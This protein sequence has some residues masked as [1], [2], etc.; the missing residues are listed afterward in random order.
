MDDRTIRVLEFDKIRELLAGECVSPMGEELARAL[1]PSTFMI[2]ITRW[3]RET[4]EAWEYLT[5]MG[6]SPVHPFDDI[7]DAL[8]RSRLGAAL[9]IPQIL[10]VGRVLSQ[11]RTLRR[12]LE[13]GGDP[14]SL[15]YGY[16]L[17]LVSLRGTEEE[18]ARCIVSEEEVADNASPDLYRIRRDIRSC[19]AR[20]R[21]R[22]N[23]MIH[24]PEMAKYLQDPII[25]MRN[26][27]Y[28][29]PVRQEFRAQ[30]P[31]LVHDQSGSGATLFVEPMAVVEINNELKE[32]LGRE[33]E[34]IHRIL[35]ELTAQIGRNAA[36]ILQAVETMAQLDFIFAKAKLSSNTHASPPTILPKGELR[37]VR[38]RHPLIDP[39]KVVPIDLQLGGAFTSLIVT[40]PNTGGKTVT[41][42]TCGLFAMMAQS[43]L[44]V[45]GDEGCT[46]P[47]Y[48]R[49]FA[50]IGDEQSIEQSL[51]TFSS[52][53]VNIVRIM[54]EVDS[55]SLVLLDELG[56]GT[57][58]TEGAALAISI[59]ERLKAVGASVA[60]TTHYSELKAYAL[61]TEGV[62]NASV[63]F[64]V[65]SLRPTYRLSIGIPGKSNAFEISR[66]LGLDPVVIDRAKDYLSKEQIRFEDVIQNAEYHRQLAEKERLVAE[67]A[68]REMEDLKRQVE[69]ERRRL[70]EQRTKI[71]QEAKEDARRTIRRAKAEADELIG[72]LKALKQSAMSAEIDRGIQQVRDNLREKERSLMEDDAPENAGEMG[73]KVTAVQ[74][75]D[76]VYITGIGQQAVVISPVDAKGMVAVQVGPMK[77]SAKLSS[78]RAL[79]K[80]ERKEAKRAERAENRTSVLRVNTVPLELDIR[81]LSAEEGVMAADKYLDDA[82]LSGVSEVSII[83]GKGTGI[84]REAITRML[85]K[86]RHVKEFR[87][88]KYGE[89]ETGVTIVR[90]K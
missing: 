86:H 26:D 46:F 34:E 82:F 61:S 38:G 67:Q 30:I 66:K 44:H 15:L 31:G 89:G 78:L 21:D 75:G 70:E 24:S 2:E 18:I 22:M 51:S 10:A 6:V 80:E 20:I 29:V 72:Q 50:D 87:I 43:G 88:G 77:M 40:G 13:E 4:T 57:D 42:K 11:S 58:P 17:S 63:E 68:A 83:H 45:P 55:Q 16:A 9:M 5:K 49:L 59:L 53:M 73:E 27:R 1:V 56:A 37:I 41:L 14:T 12:A 8:D 47:V 65:E 36:E 76:R 62:E 7:R 74:A 60:A 33:R 69:K 84:L 81:G 79:T 28:V 85:R 19:H 48:Q 39:K 52:H 32:L 90:L 64:D 54:A 35:L 23:R 3:Q 71:V 25:T